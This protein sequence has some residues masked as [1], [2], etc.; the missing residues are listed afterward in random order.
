MSTLFK[1]VAVFDFVI[2]IILSTYF[3]TK[4]NTDAGLAW[5]SS[6]NLLIGCIWGES[7]IDR[8]KKKIKQLENYEH[9]KE[10]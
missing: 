10:N 5:I 8:L 6:I 3:Y 7:R 1:I 2:F 4:G 9:N